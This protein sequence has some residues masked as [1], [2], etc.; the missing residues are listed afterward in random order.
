MKKIIRLTEGDLHRIIK[1]SVKRTL[2]E[3]SFSNNYKECLRLLEKAKSAIMIDYTNDADY[4]ENDPYY[5][6][7]NK[8]HMSIMQ[9][10]DAAISACQRIA[11]NG[12]IGTFD[13]ENGYTP[14][15]NF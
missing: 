5:D 14:D 6:E 13:A 1:E 15:P 11:L 2:N 12:R 3:G 9:K 8:G 10:I 4:D 7:L